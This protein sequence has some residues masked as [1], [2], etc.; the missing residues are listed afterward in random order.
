MTQFANASKPQNISHSPPAR[1]AVSR[2]NGGK[3]VGLR[4]YAMSTRAHTERKNMA[5]LIHEQR[6]H[7][8]Q[9]KP[10]NFEPYGSGCDW[11]RPTAPVAA[12]CLAIIC[13]P[14]Q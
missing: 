11:Q 7:V 6:W 9:P 12:C 5:E 14:N 8:R 2:V 4:L 3:V 13:L 1:F 10:G